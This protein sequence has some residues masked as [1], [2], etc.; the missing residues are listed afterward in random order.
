[1]ILVNRRQAKGKVA[2]DNSEISVPLIIKE[3]V[4]HDTYNFVFKL[5]EEDMVLGIGVGQCISLSY[6]DKK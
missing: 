1:M 2:V 4:T 3:K 5:P 6:I